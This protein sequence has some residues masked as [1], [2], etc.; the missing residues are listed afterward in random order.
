MIIYYACSRATVKALKTKNIYVYLSPPIG[1][2]QY[3]IVHN[4]GYS[5]T[6]FNPACKHSIGIA[7]KLNAIVSKQNI[8]NESLIL[9]KQKIK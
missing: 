5:D 9:K 4:N 2:T 7:Q 8:C 1:G 6:V 3:N